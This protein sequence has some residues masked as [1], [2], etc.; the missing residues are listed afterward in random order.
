MV[1]SHLKNI[2]HYRMSNDIDM[3]R[4]GVTKKGLGPKSQFKPL[5]IVGYLKDSLPS[6]YV[7]KELE[8]KGSNRNYN[9]EVILNEV[10]AKVF[11]LDR[12]QFELRVEEN[13]QENTYEMVGGYRLVKLSKIFADKIHATLEKFMNGTLDNDNNSRHIVDLMMIPELYLEDKRDK[14]NEFVNEVVDFLKDKI[15]Q[16]IDYLNRKSDVISET[17]LFSKRSI[18]KNPLFV[19]DKVMS[20]WVDSSDIENINENYINNLLYEVD[21]HIF[22]NSRLNF[23]RKILEVYNEKI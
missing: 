22:T 5:E 10:D 23:V 17:K 2:R 11:G 7:I 15:K 9:I 12:F 6:D 3:K 4:I 13:V 20:D 8:S 19:W 16:D 1:R 21:G 14:K 18:I